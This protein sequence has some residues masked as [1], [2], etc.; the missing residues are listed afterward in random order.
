MRSL[1]MEEIMR[2]QGTQGVTG[3]ESKAGKRKPAAG[4]IL[5][6][7]L[8]FGAACLLW[9]QSGIYAF[10]Q[11]TATVLAESGKI[12][13]TPSTDS[14]VLASVK[15]DDTLTVTAQTTDSQ[16]YTWYKVFVNGQSLGYVRADLVNVTGDIPTESAQTAADTASSQTSGEGTG[17]DSNTG[18]TQVTVG[19]GNSTDTQTAQE[20]PVT[21]SPSTAAAG[22]TTAAVRV[23][24]GAGTN[25]DVAGNAQAGT[26]VSILGES[27]DGSGTLWYQVSFQ[28][29][30]GTVNGFIRN[31]YLEITEYVQEA[32]A[33][34]IP[35]EGELPQEEVPAQE[36]PSENND[37]YLK[38]M[39]N[40]EAA[41]AIFLMS[42]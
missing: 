35:A 30:N 32:P 4:K 41:T 24:K 2:T 23:R 36:V 11:G 34:E 22:R 18:S 8:V 40:S 13:Q 6:L 39:E 21:S 37:Y 26:E 7:L 10:A 3:T 5:L 25:H 1:N 27:A 38:Y 42:F 14:T 16:G 28:G 9:H 20:V 33:E 17:A 12:R 29:G 19:A 15:K 31:D